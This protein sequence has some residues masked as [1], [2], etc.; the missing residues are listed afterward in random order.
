MNRGLMGVAVI[1]TVIAIAGFVVYS[2]DTKAANHLCTNWCSLPEYGRAVATAN[3][4]FIVGILA[5]VLGAVFWYETI[6]DRFQ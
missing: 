5:S 4:S 1:L 2:V 3:V 6:M